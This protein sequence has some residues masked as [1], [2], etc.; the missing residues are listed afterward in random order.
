MENNK[1]DW[2]E[3]KEDAQMLKDAAGLVFGALFW[4]FMITMG[5]WA[6]VEAI[7]QKTLT[8]TQAL[9]ITAGIGTIFLLKSWWM[10]RKTNIR[11]EKRKKEE[12]VCRK[13]GLPILYPEEM[14][15][16]L[17]MRKVFEQKSEAE[18]VPHKHL[19]S[20]AIIPP[21][22]ATRNSRETEVCFECGEIGKY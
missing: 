17:K 2:E 4:G 9:L 5:V 14:Q 1:N 6:F 22:V 7:F 19:W 3:V 11:V 13:Q 16:L 12:T 21:S 8:F 18:R 15:K 20:S 10:N